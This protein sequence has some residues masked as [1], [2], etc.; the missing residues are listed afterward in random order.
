[1]AGKSTFIRQSALIILLAHTGSFIPAKKGK[2]GIIDGI[3]TRIGSGDVLSKG[4]STFMVE[5]LEVANILNNITERS[6]VVLDEVG[7]GTSTYDGISIAWAVSEYIS[8][9]KKTKTLFATHY[10][11]LTKLEEEIPGI[12][13]FHMHIKEERRRDK[14]FIQGF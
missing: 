4:L 5:M 7:R 13:N 10:H 3:Y 11:E 1:M 12:K 14:I 9:E 2:I 8:K 6:F